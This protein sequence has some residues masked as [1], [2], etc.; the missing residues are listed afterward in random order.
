MSDHDAICPP[1]FSYFDRLMPPSDAQNY[2]VYDGSLLG[3]G[4]IDW[5]NVYSIGALTRRL[6]S[7]QMNKPLKEEIHGEFASFDCWVESCLTRH[8]G[9]V[10]G[11]VISLLFDEACGW[12]YEGVISVKIPPMTGNLVVDF[13]QSFRAGGERFRIRVYHKRTEGSKVT[14]QARLES[15]SGGVIYTD[16]TCLYIMPRSRL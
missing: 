5:F 16:A 13:R 4:L 2:A 9:V 15:V 3:P 12:G 1:T 7:C 10:H 11:G 14:L 6:Q 8:A